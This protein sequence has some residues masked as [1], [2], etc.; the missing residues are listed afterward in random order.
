VNT[1][2]ELQEKIKQIQKQIDECKDDAQA[3]LL[4]KQLIDLFRIAFNNKE[5]LISMV[6]NKNQ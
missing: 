6:N 4:Q 1:K 3:I 5:F 2:E